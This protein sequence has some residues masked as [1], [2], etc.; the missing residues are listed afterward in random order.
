MSFEDEMRAFVKKAQARERTLYQRSVEHAFDS[1]R[2]G[3]PV[4]G[5][6]GQPV[7][8][9]DL[10]ESWNLK[11][12]GRREA[13]L[14]S[15]LPYADIIEDN[16]RGAVLRSKVGGFHSVK[17]TR[18]G[19]RKIVMHELR[20]MGRGPAFGSGVPSGAPAIINNKQPRDKRG[21]YAR[22]KHARVKIRG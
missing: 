12:T 7:D 3:S 15:D 1:I 21:R 13:V 14:E 20:A 9:G 11:V 18:L 2:Y 6:P 22:T 8:Q 19:W 4:T 17:L 16:E 5:A 10:L